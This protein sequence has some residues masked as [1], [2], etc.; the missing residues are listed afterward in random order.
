MWIATAPSND[1][2]PSHL[3]GGYEGSL[4]LDLLGWTILRFDVGWGDVI[5][6]IICIYIYIFVEHYY[7]WRMIIE[8]YQPAA[9]WCFWHPRV[10]PDVFEPDVL[11]QIPNCKD[12]KIYQP[13][14]TNMESHGLGTPWCP[15]NVLGS[16]WLLSPFVWSYCFWLTKYLDLLTAEPWS[17]ARH[18]DCWG[19]PF[20]HISIRSWIWAADQGCSGSLGPADASGAQCHQTRSDTKEKWAAC[21]QLAKR[22]SLKDVLEPG[23]AWPTTSPLGMSRHRSFWHAHHL[24]STD[25][26]HVFTNWFQTYLACHFSF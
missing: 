15:E 8:Y 25:G 9:A 3:L 4:L 12:V 22:F 21:A 13:K 17:L 5:H 19:L 11:H 10:F 2:K 18:P 1:H 14:P 6:V 26:L 20:E 7:S 23:K 24:T 16:H